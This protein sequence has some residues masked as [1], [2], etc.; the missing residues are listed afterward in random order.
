M[1]IAGKVYNPLKRLIINIDEDLH[2]AQ[3][4]EFNALFEQSLFSFAVGHLWPHSHERARHLPVSGSCFRSSQCVR[5]VFCPCVFT[6]LLII[7]DYEFN[8]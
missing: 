8:F 7:I 2:V 5:F 3:L 6:L 1:F 4:A